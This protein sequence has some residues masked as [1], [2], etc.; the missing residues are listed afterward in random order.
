[1]PGLFRGDALSGKTVCATDDNREDRGTAQNE[2]DFS[3][4][5]MSTALDE[6]GAMTKADPCG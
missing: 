3:V 1:M 2:D 6:H 5:E 4:T